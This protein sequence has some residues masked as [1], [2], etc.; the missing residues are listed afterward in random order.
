MSNF[1]IETGVPYPITQGFSIRKRTPER[2]AIEELLRNGNPG[3]SIFF[4]GFNARKIAA[5]MFTSQKA[6]G[7]QKMLSSRTVEDGVRV[8]R[9]AAPEVDAQ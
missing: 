9:L 2:D 5:L 3:D 1:V 6:A 8:W 7:V 4:E